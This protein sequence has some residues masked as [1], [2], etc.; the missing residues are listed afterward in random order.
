MKVLIGTTNPSKLRMFEEWLEGY[1]VEFVTL[2]ELGITGDPSETGDT[3]TENAR[4]KAEYYGQFADY[5]ICQDSGLYL[6]A[7]PLDD[8]RQP[9][10]HIRT[11]QGK[12]LSDD[13]MIAYYSSLAGSLGGKVM[14]YYLDGFAVKTPEGIQ[15]YM[16]SQEEARDGA[17]WLVDKPCDKRRPGWPLDSISLMMDGSYFLDNQYK[18]KSKPCTDTNTK[19]AWVRFLVNA[20]GL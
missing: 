17:F 4:L 14:A 11:P 18:L 10:L 15:T 1:P 9:G 2:S 3:P 7:L 8:P 19:K 20:L 6:D 12:R 16:K 5:C 13:E